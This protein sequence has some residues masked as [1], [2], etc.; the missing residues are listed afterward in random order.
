MKTLSDSFT[1]EDLKS[2]PPQL[3]EGTPPIRLAVFGDPVDHS[4]S[5]ALQNAGLKEIHADYGYAKF[6]I[7]PDQLEEALKLAR[8]ND[9][10]GV[11]CTIPHKLTAFSLM[12]NLDESAQLLGAVN[13]VLFEGE[14]MIG[15]NTDGRG[16]VR[17]VHAEFGMDLRDLR[18]MILGAGGGAGR[19]L[20]VQCA[21]EDCERLILVNRTLEKAQALIKE[22]HPHFQ[23]P[24]VDAPNS[25]LLCVPWE[26]AA[27]EA[28]L[29]QIDLIVQCTSLGLKRSD[30]PALAPQL[31]QPYHLVFDT[32]YRPGSNATKL[33][34]DARSRGARASDGLPLLLHQGALSLEI[35]SEKTAPLP[36][37]RRALYEAAGRPLSA[38]EDLPI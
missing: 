15:Y 29:S 1:F 28:E 27:L 26:E 12:T 9:F 3:E 13:T 22:L 20:A 25:R 14:G 33:V 4:L 32:V 31:L 35:W 30:P 38:W 17:A 11:N 2:W 21:L 16:F 34:L 8:Q 23:T 7:K 36:V 18:V 37:M 19:A 10:V 24:R 5:P 6:H